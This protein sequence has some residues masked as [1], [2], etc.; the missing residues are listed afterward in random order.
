M[1]E[2]QYFTEKVHK[3]VRLATMKISTNDRSI[4][5][6]CVYMPLNLYVNLPI[7]TEYPSKISAIIEDHSEF[8]ALGDFN[9]HPHKVY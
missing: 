3:I 1:E 6:F 7:F 4:I 2:Q 8:E 5:V 9:A